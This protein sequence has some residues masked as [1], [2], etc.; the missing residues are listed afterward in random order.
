MHIESVC[1][2]NEG[3]TLPTKPTGAL[4]DL[5]YSPSA[6][7]PCLFTGPAGERLVTYVDDFLLTAKN[8]LSGLCEWR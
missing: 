4:A 6:A 7:D 5:A 3:V 2:A 8:S 1:M